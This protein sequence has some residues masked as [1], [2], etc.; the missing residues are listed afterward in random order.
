MYYGQHKPK[1]NKWSRLRNELVITEKQHLGEVN[2]LDDVL[3][4]V[5]RDFISC[6]SIP[7]LTGR[8]KRDKKFSNTANIGLV[9]T[10]PVP[11]PWHIHSRSEVSC[12]SSRLAGISVETGPPHSTLVA[13]KCANPVP[14]VPLAEHWLPI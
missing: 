12:S 6:N 5:R 7:Y 14:C 1:K 13:L 9:V 11:P 10:R 8:G 4:A 2:R 3:V